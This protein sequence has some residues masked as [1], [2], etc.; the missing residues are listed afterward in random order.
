MRKKARLLA[1]NLR[2][3]SFNAVWEKMALVCRCAKLVFQDDAARYNL[4]L[5]SDGK[6][7]ARKRLLM[8]NDKWLIVNS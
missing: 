1:T 2:I 6:N 4:F 3:A 8:V 5:L 7:Q